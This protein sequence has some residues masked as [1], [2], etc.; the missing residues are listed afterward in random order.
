MG[1]VSG[2]RAVGEA[3][4]AV[5][6]IA[7]WCREVGARGV[8]VCQSPR[9]PPRRCCHP[10]PTHLCEL[11]HPRACELVLEGVGGLHGLTAADGLIH[12]GGNCCH[13]LERRLGVGPV[14]VVLGGRREE[15]SAHEAEGR[16]ERNESWV[17][18]DSGESK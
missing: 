12:G 3:S 13:V 17:W 14:W 6:E 7:Q 1:C 18:L 10:H 2:I 8:P 4:R 11:V 9:R 5:G 15:L 16:K